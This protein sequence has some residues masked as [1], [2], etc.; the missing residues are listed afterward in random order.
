MIEKVGV[1]C[2]LSNED[3]F[4]QNKLDDSNSIVNQKSMC[5]K[6]AKEKN[7]NIID[8]YSDDDFS[9]AGTYRPEFE[10]LIADCESGRINIVICKTQSRFS[11]DME[12]IERYLHNKFLEWG[13]RFISIVDNADTNIKSN[14][15]SRQING[16]MNE[17]YLEDLSNNIKRSLKNKREDGQFIGSFAPYGYMKD[18][19]DKHKLIIDPVASEVVKKIFEMYANGYG[20]HKICEYLNNNGIVPRTIYKR[21]KGSKFVC[22]GANMDTLK[23]RPDS[24]AQLLRQE[25]YIGNLVQ[26][27]KTSLSYKIHKFRNVEKENW[28]KIEGTH[29]AIIDMDTWNI[30]QKRLGDHQTPIKNGEIHFFTRKVY[31]SCCEKSFQRNVYHVKGEDTGKRAYLQCRGHK[32]LHEC[33][34]N[35]AIRID[36]LENIVLNAIKDLLTEFYDKDT[37]RVNYEMINRKNSNND[38]KIKSLEKEKKELNERIVEVRG[39]FK[40][41]YEDKL[42]GVLTDKMFIDMSNDYTEEIEKHVKRIQTIDSEIELLKPDKSP[43]KKAEDVLKKYT[44]ITKLNKVIVDEFIDRIYIGEYDKVNKT[45]DIEIIWNFEF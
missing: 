41:L 10:R 40:K 29:E 12:V 44:K 33:N 22:Y 25:V 11:R 14:K 7:W 42:K 19:D 32:R 34:N 30:V 17:W 2:R 27:R 43:K 45:R 8:I 35:K 39:F 31:C 18:P 21:Q 13:V 3:R 26:G 1:Y 24:I 28:C 6:Y 38:S 4:K 23:W 9:G 5:I 20:Y 16:L 15:K 36:E 37:I